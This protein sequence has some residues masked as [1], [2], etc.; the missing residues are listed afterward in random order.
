MVHIVI[1]VSMNTS[2]ENK[3]INEISNAM[4]ALQDKKKVNIP[5]VEG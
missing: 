2:V 4:R 3:E 1:P 5:V